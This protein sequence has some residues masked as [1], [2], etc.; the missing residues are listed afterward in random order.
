MKLTVNGVEHE[1]T[2]PPLTPLLLRAPRGARDHEPEGRLPAGRL[3]L[4]HR[5]RR[6]E[7]RGDRACSPPAALDG[8][9][10]TTLEGLG[11][12]E[13]LSPIQAAFHERYAAQC[14]FC[15]LRHGGRRPRVSRGRRQLRA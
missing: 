12:A 9:E 11:T 4:L 2:S 10:I 13:E 6:A 1:L 8:A 5:S 3:R 7:S 15:T 14:G